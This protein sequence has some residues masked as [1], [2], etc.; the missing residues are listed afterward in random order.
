MNLE[1]L[2]PENWQEFIADE[3]AVLVLGKTGCPACEEWSKELEES[4]E[5]LGNV[6]VGK[7]I[8]NQK[9]LLEFKKANTWLAEVDI[10]PY[11]VIL[12]KW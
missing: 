2:T 5:D 10:L 7:L 9:G 11:N 8:I 1:I 6:R 4:S 12:S 3:T